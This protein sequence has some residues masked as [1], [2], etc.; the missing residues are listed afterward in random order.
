MSRIGEVHRVTKE[1]E[2]YVKVNLDEAGPIHVDTPYRFLNHIVETLLFYAS[3]SGEVT[4]REIKPVDDHH[5]VEDVAICLGKAIADALEKS[6]NNIARYGWA[7]IPMD[8]A[9]VLAAV[10]LGGRIFLE[11]N[12]RF[13][14]EKIGDVAT[15]NIHH[16][17][18]SF[19]Q[20]LCATIHIHVISG[21]NEHHVVEAACKALGISLGQ[22]TRIVE[23]VVST[24]GAVRM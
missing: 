9:C 6:R 18:Y 13:K 17:F 22:A 2:V 12:Y 24:K 3:F 15:E 10:D 21:I 11:F 23:R 16:F 20:N 4:V 14:R 7:I 1:T 8:D 19:A 5:V